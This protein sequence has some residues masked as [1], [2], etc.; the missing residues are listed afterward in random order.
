M[1]I[2]TSIHEFRLLLESLSTR[3]F[4][5]FVYD[6]L[7]SSGEFQKTEFSSTNIDQGVDI[8][9]IE[10]ETITS[11]KFPTKWLIEIKK[12]KL[13][14]TDVIS[15]LIYWHSNLPENNVKFGIVTI[16]QLTTQAKEIAENNNVRI[17][18]FNEIAGLTTP[19]IYE[20][21][22]GGNF[23][24][25]NEIPKENLYL[26]QL[27]NIIPGKTE[28]SKYQ[29]FISDTFEFMFCPT[30]ETPRYEHP[31]REQDNR[32][33]MIFENSATEGFWKTIKDTY[34]G[35][36]VV[37]DAKNYS[38]ELSKKPIIEVAHYLKPY[39]CGM[40]A[41]ITSRKGMSKAARNA[42]REQW[43]GN[44]KMIIVLDDNDI[45][46]ML[47]IKSPEELL[48][49]KIADFRMEL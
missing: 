10:K 12:T 39:G 34:E 8:I 28:W 48:R 30:L 32:R 49:K 36:Y 6:I 35:H 44:N 2:L 31:D 17:W 24:F 18:G 14:G 27:S 37:V 3:D 11:P 25:K 19:E 15:Q 22:F 26:S 46:E 16:G 23:E 20:K 45:I 9:A 42:V 47:Q 43:I 41:I 29:K 4:E 13:I 21:Y 5:K 1:K 38:N 33:D 7:I 40:F